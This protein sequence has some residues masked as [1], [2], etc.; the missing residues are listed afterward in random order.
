MKTGVKTA[1]APPHAGKG[2]GLLGTTGGRIGCTNLPVD[3]NY[4][5]CGKYFKNRSC[6]KLLEQAD[7]E[8]IHP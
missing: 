5:I 4:K 6:L 3:D 1:V 2:H 8:G 7:A